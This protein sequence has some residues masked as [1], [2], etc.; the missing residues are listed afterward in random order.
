M[1]FRLPWWLLA[2][3]MRNSLGEHTQLWLVV[4]IAMTRWL[5]IIIISEQTLSSASLQSRNTDDLCQLLLGRSLYEHT[6]SPLGQPGRD[7]RGLPFM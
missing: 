4:Q 1:L 2:W 7:L 3:E 6:S 5:A